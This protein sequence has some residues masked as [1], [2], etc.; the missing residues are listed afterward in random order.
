MLGWGVMEL[1][2][3]PDPIIPYL[4][5]RGAVERYREGAPPQAEVPAAGDRSGSS[6]EQLGIEA[7]A[8]CVGR[9]LRWDGTGMG[10]TGTNFPL[11]TAEPEPV[12][13]A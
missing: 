13:V 3:T 9:G 5:S 4:C 7:L 11:S 8:R 6:E 12:Q 2:G 10:P 1:P